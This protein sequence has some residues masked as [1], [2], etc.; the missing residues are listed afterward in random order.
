VF[1]GR[2]TRLFWV[3]LAT[4]VLASLVLFTMLYLIFVYYPANYIRMHWDYPTHFPAYFWTYYIWQ[5]LGAG[6]F[7]ALGLLL[8][9]TG[10]KK[11]DQEQT[12]RAKTFK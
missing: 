10:R 5:I 2:K 11:E 6:A 8:M 4:S 12:Q 7:L 3:G 9:K 1:E